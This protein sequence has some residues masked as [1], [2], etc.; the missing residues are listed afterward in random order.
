MAFESAPT[1]PVLKLKDAEADVPTVMPMPD[2]K[3]TADKVP[4]LTVIPEVPAN[5]PEPVIRVPAFTLV[6]PE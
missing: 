3:S 5:A 4:P 6:A 1:V 2:L